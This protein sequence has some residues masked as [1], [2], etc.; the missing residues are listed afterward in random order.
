MG[1]TQLGPVTHLSPSD[2]QNLWIGNGGDPTKGVLTSVVFGAENPQGNAGIVNDTPR[3]GR[4]L[5]RALADQLLRGIVA[6]HSR[7]VWVP[8]GLRGGSQPPGQSRNRDVP[9]R[10]QLAAVGTGLRVLGVRLRGLGPA[11]RLEGRQLARGPRL[12]VD[13]VLAGET[14]LASLSS[15]PWAPIRGHCGDPRRGGTRPRGGSSPT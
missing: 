7:E 6:T 13:V 3:D 15:L 11:R 2:V 14:A 4:L 1:D 12:C 10:F 5:H 9:E 8:Q